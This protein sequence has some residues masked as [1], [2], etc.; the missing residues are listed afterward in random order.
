M[1]ESFDY[2]IGTGLCLGF[3]FMHPRLVDPDARAHEGAG[4]AKP[5]P[6]AERQRQDHKPDNLGRVHRG[7][8]F[9]RP[10]SH[11]ESPA[12]RLKV[13]LAT[14]FRRAGAQRRRGL[15]PPGK[16]GPSIG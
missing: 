1:S 5:G 4:N 16:G 8:S 12:Q 11:L 14:R 6:G 15:L 9:R 7:H 13:R 10:V 3:Q 2:V